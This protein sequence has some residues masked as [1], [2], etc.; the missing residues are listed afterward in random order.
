MKY[1]TIAVCF[2]FIQ[3]STK[4]Q[5]FEGRS[6]QDPKELAGENVTSNSPQ[7]RMHFTQDTLPVQPRNSMPVVTFKTRGK[8]QGS[9]GAGAD[10]YAMEPDNMPCLVPKSLPYMPAMRMPLPGKRKP[11]TPLTEEQQK[12]LNERLQQL[13]KEPKKQS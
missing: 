1:L 5:V 8:Y 3:Y 10:I 9:N 12:L 7:I 2:L 11:S 6:K 13:S 4:A